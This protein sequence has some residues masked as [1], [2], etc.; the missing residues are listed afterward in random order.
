M[1]F[2]KK[3]IYISYT[4]YTTRLVYKQCYIAIEKTISPVLLNQTIRQNHRVATLLILSQVVIFIVNRRLP[5][6]A[7]PIR[8]CANVLV[9]FVHECIDNGWD[10]G[11]IIVTK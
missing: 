8:Y 7:L 9:S 1:R 10:W 5:L 2:V 3:V 6:R 4:S 11:M